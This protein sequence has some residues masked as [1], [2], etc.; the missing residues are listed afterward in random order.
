MIQKIFLMVFFLAVPGC[1]P[2][3]SE[4]DTACEVDDDCVL[5]NGSDCGEFSCGCRYAAIA[6]TDLKR[7]EQDRWACADV[8]PGVVCECYYVTARCI[9]QRCTS[10]SEE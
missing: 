3:I 2:S 1:A 4:Y 8:N 5:V 10:Q 6:R 7:Y 9:E